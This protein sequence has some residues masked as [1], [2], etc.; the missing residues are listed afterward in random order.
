MK[1]EIFYFIYV[2]N[3]ESHLF[4]K[5]IKKFL[6]WFPDSKKFEI[7]NSESF[8]ESTLDIKLGKKIV[9]FVKINIQGAE[10]FA[11][12]GIDNHL[13]DCLGIEP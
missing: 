3:L 4:L 8:N 1:N 11:L 9:D 10:I 12:K 2:I 5:R 13:C 7:I 6:E